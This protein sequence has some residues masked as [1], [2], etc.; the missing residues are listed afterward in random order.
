MHSCKGKIS[1]SSFSENNKNY[2][3][4]VFENFLKR[5]DSKELGMTKNKSFLEALIYFLHC[6]YPD[7]MMPSYQR[8]RWAVVYFGVYISVV[9]YFLMNLV[10][11]Y[12]FHSM[13]KYF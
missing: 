12:V 7:V 5:A 13:K 2:S 9:L 6:S 1:K 8:S 3:W 10:R 11:L 4:R